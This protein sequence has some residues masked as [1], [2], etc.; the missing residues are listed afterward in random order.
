[1][2][3]QWR[4]EARSHP[5]LSICGSSADWKKTEVQSRSRECTQ[6]GG[7]RVDKRQIS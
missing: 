2:R 6:K 3:R 4:P 7:G 5:D 1:M